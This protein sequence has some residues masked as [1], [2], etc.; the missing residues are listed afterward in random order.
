MATKLLKEKLVPKTI[1][2]GFVLKLLFIMF[3]VEFVKGALIITFLPIYLDDVLK[4]GALVIGWTLAVQYLGDNLLRTPI[5]WLI[6]Q[7][8]YRA[9][10][11]TGVLSTFASVAIIAT[12]S[13]YFW[14][15]VACALLGMGTA[16]LW[17][18]VITGTTE[19]AGEKQRGT[20][21]GVVYMAWLS[22]VGL[23][24]FV[25]TFFIGNDHYQSAFRLLIG[26]MIA[27]VIVAFLLPGMEKHL[28][29]KEAEKAKMQK[30]A[31]HVGLKRPGNRFQ[32]AQQYLNEV[33]KSLTMSPLMFPAMFFQTFALGLLTPVLTLYATKILALSG[34]QYRYFLL[35]G[36]LVTVLFMVPVGKLVDR[37]GTKWFLHIGFLLSS[38]VLLGFTY[39][40][41]MPMLYTLVVLLGASYALLIPAWNALIAAAIPPEKRGAVWGFFLTIEGLGTTIGPVVSGKIWDD[42][43]Y[44]APF[45]ASGSVLFVLFFVHIYISQKNKG[46]LQHE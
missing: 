11:L 42:I 10:M 37:W 26:I 25:I 35:A 45:L 17:P 23:G 15:I 1:F 31:A 36:G 34:E 24:P 21:M 3:F 20:I 6:D 18:C 38:L 13:S 43:S 8:G 33:R 44:H 46:V 14:I 32:R 2:S 19:I 30:N 12:T 40:R 29:S 9:C 7:I 4:V 16:P 5:G 39:T 22:G 27:V 28:Q 41:S